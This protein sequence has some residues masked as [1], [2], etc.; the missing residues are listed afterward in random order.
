M[1][2]KY[3]IYPIK[4]FKKWNDADYKFVINKLPYVDVCTLY[5]WLHYDPYQE[6][7]LY[8]LKAL[9]TS[10]EISAMHYTYWFINVK[11]L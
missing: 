6:G 10:F 5:L 2:C 8:L 11:H 3:R 9:S 1:K 7:M 4:I